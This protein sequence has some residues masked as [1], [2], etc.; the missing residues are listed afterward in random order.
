MHDQYLQLH[1][2]KKMSV[3][4]KKAVPVRLNKNYKGVPNPGHIGTSSMKLPPA[5]SKTCKIPGSSRL[6]FFTKWDGLSILFATFRP[7]F[8]SHQRR[9]NRGET[10]SAL[11]GVIQQ[12]TTACHNS[13][14]IFDPTSDNQTADPNFQIPNPRKQAWDRS[15]LLLRRLSSILYTQRNEEKKRPSF[16]T[17]RPYF[18]ELNGY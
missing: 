16:F 9:Y 8:V 14:T 10:I 7:D 3:V 17:G 2:R 1:R 4:R 6:T 12:V 15:S 13:D 11:T 18:C 5:T